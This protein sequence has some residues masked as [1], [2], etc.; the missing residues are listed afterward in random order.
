MTRSGG[1]QTYSMERGYLG[2]RRLLQRRQAWAR[3]SLL[4]L[5]ALH[6]AVWFVA[7]RDGDA[8]S[9]MA[10]MVFGC[11]WI[12]AVFAVLNTARNR[13]ERSLAFLFPLIPTSDLASIAKP[14]LAGGAGAE[15]VLFLLFQLPSAA[16]AFVAALLTFLGRDKIPGVRYWFR[17]MCVHYAVCCSLIYLWSQ[18]RAER[19]PIIFGPVECAVAVELALVSACLCLE[20]HEKIFPRALQRTP[21]IELAEIDGGELSPVLEASH[22]PNPQNPALPSTTP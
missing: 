19:Y 4:P 6:F 17:F 13:M 15:D 1:E 20:F 12:I 2:L 5:S 10:G 8:L 7:S 9:K 11:I 14:F 18:G 3:V 21:V 22:R 16:A